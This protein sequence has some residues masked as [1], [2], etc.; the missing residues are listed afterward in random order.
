VDPSLER[1]QW[2]RAEAADDTEVGSD[3]D[4]EE[5]G[6][7][8]KPAKGYT[9][10]FDIVRRFAQPLGIH[11]DAWDG[12]IIETEKGVVRLLPVTERARQLFGDEGAAGLAD[13][14]ERAPIS[15]RQ[16]ELFPA[17][18]EA[19]ESQPRGRRRRFA[20]TDAHPAVTPRCCCKPAVGPMGY[21][22]SSPPN[23]SAALT[24]CGSAT[25]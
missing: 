17:A 19:A 5:D 4:A 8:R 11:L 1:R 13:R 14:I 3:E 16:L 23:R 6:G 10:I 2:C 21:A 25:R 22:P 9:L 18:R 20:I 7:G 24:S 12:R 15:A